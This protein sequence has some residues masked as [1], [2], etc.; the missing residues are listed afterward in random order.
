M[1][2][3]N[4]NVIN[5]EVWRLSIPNILSNISVPLLSTV[6]TALM[7]SLSINHVGA[8]AIGGMIFNF[9]FW[10]L[11]FLRMSSTGLIAQAYGRRNEQEAVDVLFKGIFIA[12]VLSI[13]LLLGRFLVFDGLSIV[14]DV[15]AE[16]KPAILEYFSI[17]SWAIPAN[18]LML[19]LFGWFFGRQNAIIPLLITITINVVN[20]AL[21]YYLVIERGWEIA[22]TAYGTV[23]AQYIGLFVA[24]VFL[25]WKN[26]GLIVSFMERIKYV[27]EGLKQ[28][29]SVNQNIFVRTLMLSIAFLLI[30]RL[31]ANLNLEILAINAILLQYLNWMSYFIDGFAY[32]AESL[33]GKYAGRKDSEGV[34]LAIRQSFLW[35]GVFAVFI[36]FVYAIFW[37]PLFSLF[38]KPEDIYLLDKASP[39]LPWIVIMPLGGFFCY[40][41]D[42]IFVGLSAA[43]AMRN[44]M[45]ISFVVYLALIYLGR[46]YLQNHAIWLAFFVFLVVRGVFQYI[47]FKKYGWENLT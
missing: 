46:P 33:V 14:L 31:S 36:A 20:I 30:F 23:C 28:L 2:T 34:K 10:N 5:R 29:L 3:I 41:W 43:K 9:L 12:S 32:A 15:T 25:I 42:G 1:E 26:G 45:F 38:V 17:R 47:L 18:L 27:F 13:F 44:S 40:I 4:K 35:G 21:S 22:G 8:V 37:S 6:D 7:G 24:F 16:T 11:G 19:V 39:Y